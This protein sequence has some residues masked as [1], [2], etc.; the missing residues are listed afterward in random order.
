MGI[1]VS[2]K[3][4]VRQSNPIGMALGATTVTSEPRSKPPARPFAA[5]P[6]T[7]PRKH[8]NHLLDCV[9]VTDTIGKH[10]GKVG[11]PDPLVGGASTPAT[12]PSPADVVVRRLS[13]RQMS[14]L[15]LAGD[16]FLVAAPSL[17]TVE[18]PLCVRPVTTRLAVK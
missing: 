1:G 5:R 12:S 10:A 18:R 16:T 8:M 3:S 7:H 17:T 11:V 2:L 14:H 6:R 13:M 4:T 15:T 9:E